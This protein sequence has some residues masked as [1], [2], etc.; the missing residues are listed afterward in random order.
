VD[1]PLTI[2]CLKLFGATR[3]KRSRMTDF[4][5][6]LVFRRNLLAG[7]YQAKRDARAGRHLVQG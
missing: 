6:F 3:N 4:Y 7:Y 1:N 5:Y 2:A